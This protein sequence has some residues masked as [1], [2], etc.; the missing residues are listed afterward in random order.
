MKNTI[1]K[2]VIFAF[3]SPNDIAPV[4]SFCQEPKDT[5]FQE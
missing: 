4:N 3:Y 2:I 5:F 1:P